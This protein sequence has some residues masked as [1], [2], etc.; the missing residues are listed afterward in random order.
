MLPLDLKLLMNYNTFKVLIMSTSNNGKYLHLCVVLTFIGA[1]KFTY[2]KE[3]L[4]TFCSQDLNTSF[5][6][7]HV[8]F[9]T[10]AYYL[11]LHIPCFSTLRSF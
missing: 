4:T 5:L 10:N 3:R 9:V 1:L 11:W 2:V 8:C 7:L 6:L